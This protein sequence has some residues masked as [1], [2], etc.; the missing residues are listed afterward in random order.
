M[1]FSENGFEVFRGLLAE[2][3]ISL[4]EAAISAS[5]CQAIAGP[6]LAGFLVTLEKWN[7]TCEVDRDLIVLQFGVEGSRFDFQAMETMSYGLLADFC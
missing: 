1:S 7:C 6:N 3:D 2:S 5:R 4:A